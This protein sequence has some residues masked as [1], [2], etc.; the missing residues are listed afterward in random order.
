[1]SN[2]PPLFSVVRD[3]LSPYETATPQVVEF[4]TEVGQMQSVGAGE[5]V[6]HAGGSLNTLYIVVSG[7]LYA[8][9]ETREGKSFCKEMYWEQDVIF[10]FRS[11]L[12]GSPLPFSISALEPCVLVAVD[13]HCYQQ[14]LAASPAL[15]QFHQS[16]ICM[17]YMHKEGKEELLLLNNPKQ[18]VRYFFE[19][20]PHLLQRAPQH[21]IASY[22]GITPI[23]FSRIKKILA[24]EEE[25]C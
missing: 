10:A 5:R 13:R 12:T 11:L 9:F 1:M 3:A 20:Y 7:L 8:F 14:Q 4:F 19:R 22:L 15:Q 6:M 17:N 2:S 18:R 24:S 16:M 21:V 25:G 23:S